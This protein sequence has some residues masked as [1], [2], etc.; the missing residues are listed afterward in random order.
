VTPD[1]PRHEPVLYDP[2]TARL[3]GM[4]EEVRLQQAAGDYYT[5]DDIVRELEAEFGTGEEGSKT[6]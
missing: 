5:M 1:R 3:M 2:E 6:G 4:T